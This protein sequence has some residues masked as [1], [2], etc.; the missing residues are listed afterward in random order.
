[1]DTL[2]FHPR[3]V[4]VPIALGVLMPLVAGGILICWWR[5]WLPRRSWFVPIVL[6][7]ILVGAGFV[8]LQ[9][10]EHEEERVE[11]VVPEAYIEKHED[12]GK[13]FVWASSSVLVSMLGAAALGPRRSAL[14]V[15]GLATLGTLAA[16]WL[17]YR[18]GQQGGALV[19]E[20]GAGSAYAVPARGTAPAPIQDP[21]RYDDG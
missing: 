1:M 14:P 20:H 8:A 21:G 3:V 5:G 16:L 7:S 15:A 12:S 10:G 2:F 19:Y 9:S 4:H 17:G 11:Q 18:T 6:Q 13:T